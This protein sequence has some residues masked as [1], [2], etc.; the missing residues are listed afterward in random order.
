MRYVAL[1]VGTGALAAAAGAP[2]SAAA[3]A[4]AAA[5]DSVVLER[6]RCFGPCPAYRLSITRAGRVAFASRNPRDSTRAVVDGAAPGAVDALARR[7]EASGFFGLPPEV[8]RDPA[9][10]PDRATDHPTVI[11]T[12]FRPGGPARVEDYHGCYLANDHAVAPALAGLRQLE[13][14]IDSAAGSARWVRPVSR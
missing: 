11:V 8:A 10:C 3:Q 7:A 12:V 13:A 2:A 1:L 14:A 9:L 6:T 4:T 5:A